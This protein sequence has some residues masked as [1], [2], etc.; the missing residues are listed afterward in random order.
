[1]K[2]Y[3][4][5][6]TAP[7]ILLLY[8]FVIRMTNLYN[9]KI[10]DIIPPGTKEKGEKS[11]AFFTEED[12][13]ARTSGGR[14]LRKKAAKIF[15]LALLSLFIGAGTYGYFAFQG[16]EVVIRPKIQEMSFKEKLNVDIK[17]TIPDIS[18]NTIPG[19]VLEDFQK[20]SVDFPA[21]GKTQKSTKA[22]GIIRVYNAYSTTSQA[23]VATTRFV[24]ADGK[25]FRSKEAVTVPGGQYEKG[26]IVP[27]FAD[28]KVQADKAGSDYNIE[29]STFSIPGFAGTPRYTSFYGKSTEPMKGG[30]LGEAKEATKENIE[31]AEELLR[32]KLS[33]TVKDSLKGQDAAGIIIIEE[34]SKKDFKNIIFSAKAGDIVDSFKAEGEIYFKALTFRKSDIE[35]FVEEYILARLPEGQ[36]LDKKS[37]KIDYSPESVVIDSG[38]M[39]LNVGFSINVYFKVSDEEIKKE[40]G[41]K[42]LSSAKESL[43]NDP[44]ILKFDI[45]TWPF[46]AKNI[47]Q[48][49]EKIRIEQKL[50]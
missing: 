26:K 4:K 46:W 32:E 38:K 3:L 44:R 24:S 50:D 49:F 5:K 9:T 21:T 1:M 29:P 34:A 45:K 41:G 31:K 47:P 23:L 36:D 25:L 8:Y 40:I 14:N 22:E 10:L 7:N 39:V 28:V 27:G 12:K 6:L 43:G 18:S 20:V 16:A 35:D 42:P 37:L 11:N 2:T 13:K 15:F 33:E 30:S 48:R 19:K 17:N